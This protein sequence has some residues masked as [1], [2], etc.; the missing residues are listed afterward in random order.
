MVPDLIWLWQFIQMLTEGIVAFFPFV[1][2]VWQYLQSISYWPA[3][4]LCEKAIGCS[5]AYPFW[6]PTEN[7]ALITALNPRAATMNATMKM[8]PRLRVI[9][10]ALM[11]E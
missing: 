5:G 2:P 1:T 9:D 3:W 6:T 8:N 7:S 4:I 10:P 11:G